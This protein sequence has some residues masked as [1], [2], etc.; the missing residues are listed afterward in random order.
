MAEERDGPW[1]KGDDGKW[2]HRIE[3]DGKTYID[4]ARILTSDEC[5][6]LYN[7]GRPLR[8]PLWLRICN[9]LGI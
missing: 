2:H 9:W 4:G 7:G 3:V 5:R 6:V 1:E 8:Y